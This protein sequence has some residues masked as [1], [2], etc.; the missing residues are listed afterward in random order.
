MGI[1]YF[2]DI[3]QSK[4]WL[5]YIIFIIVKSIDH[6]TFLLKNACYDA[7]K[8]KVKMEILGNFFIWQSADWTINNMCMYLCVREKVLAA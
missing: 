8:P 6:F 3:L 2:S 5:N 1:L 7:S 4:L